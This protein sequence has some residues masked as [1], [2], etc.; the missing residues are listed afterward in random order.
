MSPRP[1]EFSDF[2]SAVQADVRAKLEGREPARVSQEAIVAQQSR[3]AG[4]QKRV[5]TGRDFEAELDITHA[6]YEFRK[7]GK[8][9]RNYV[10]TR[11]VGKGKR[12]AAGP[13]HVDR[14]GWVCVAFNGRAD[15]GTEWHHDGGRIL[16]V[17][18]DA[19]V[20]GESGRIGWY[21]H[22][23]ELQHQL[24]DLK[25]AADAGEYA[26]LLVLERRIGRVFAISIQPYYTALFQHGVQ[27]YSDEPYV[28]FL[29]SI[30]KRNEELGWDWI[31]LLAHC[32][33]R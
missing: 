30:T 10:P 27:L 5:K 4:A 17:A 25:D 15:V 11:M 2:S 22:D 12:V 26:F 20:N 9:R 19:K 14:T 8:I 3:R 24:H 23:K 31:P 1:V 21:Q 7:W 33:P 18:F 16:P 29:P 32:A 6:G 28:P 13:A